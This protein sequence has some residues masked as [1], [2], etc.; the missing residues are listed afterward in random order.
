MS[1]LKVLNAAEFDGTADAIPAGKPKR[2]TQLLIALE[3]NASLVERI[4]ELGLHIQG[5]NEQHRDLIE[6]KQAELDYKLTDLDAKIADLIEAQAEEL[7]GVNGK[8]AEE[9]K[10]H[11]YTK[12]NK[13]S[14]YRQNQD[15]TKELD[16]MHEILDMLPNVPAHKYKD[17]NDYDQERSLTVRF[18][19]MMAITSHMQSM[20]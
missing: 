20:K 12:S 17:K 5:L 8:L 9:V 16:G 11:G 15:L 19:T 2:R 7:R 13:D 14:Y 18:S 3:A 4:K 10:Q 6:Q 1:Q